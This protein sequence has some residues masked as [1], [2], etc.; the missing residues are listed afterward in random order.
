M[1]VCA[2]VRACAWALAIWCLCLLCHVSQL[3]LLFFC[4]YCPTTG[5]DLE[6]GI[7]GW[8]KSHSSAG[9]SVTQHGDTELSSPLTQPDSI[10]TKGGSEA[11]KTDKDQIDVA[12]SNLLT[13]NDVYA[14]RVLKGRLSSR[15]WRYVPFLPPNM[16]RYE[17]ANSAT[18]WTKQHRKLP[19]LKAT[20]VRD[21]DGETV[22][23]TEIERE[24][25]RETEI[26][27]DRKRNCD[28][29]RDKQRD[30][31]RQRQ[32][33]CDRDRDRQRH[34]DCDRDGDRDRETVTET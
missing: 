3:L 14:F 32:R 17:G 26:D 33:N 9:N 25:V 29:D 31:D 34:R 2:C 5:T 28:R 4:S 8:K 6:R 22:R 1:C 21:R 11:V 18:I 23:E 24:T 12:A 7:T 30:K 10:D 20:A 13:E 27:R 16:I 19:G 15:L